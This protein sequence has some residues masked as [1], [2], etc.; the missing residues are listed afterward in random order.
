MEAQPRKRKQE[1]KEGKIPKL[2][3]VMSRGKGEKTRMR[4]E[5]SPKFCAGQLLKEK[6]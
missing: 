2:N 5:G 6:C 3:F 1:P 4:G